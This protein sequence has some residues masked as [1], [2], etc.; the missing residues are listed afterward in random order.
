LHTYRIVRCISYSRIDIDL[1]MWRVADPSFIAA[2]PGRTIT[3]Q[4][5]VLQRYQLL[6]GHVAKLAIPRGGSAFL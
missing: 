5:P 4:A 6:V 1:R 2:E 3:L